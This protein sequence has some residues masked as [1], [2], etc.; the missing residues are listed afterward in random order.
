MHM[1]DDIRITEH[2]TLICYKLH[3]VARI[4]YNIVIVLHNRM[5]SEQLPIIF[6]EPP[7]VNQKGLQF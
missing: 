4:G 3:Q 6:D 7:R 5:P 2:S 1:Y